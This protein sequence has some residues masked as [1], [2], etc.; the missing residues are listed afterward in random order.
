MFDFGTGKIRGLHR[1][2]PAKARNAKAAIKTMPQMTALNGP[3]R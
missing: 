1:F 2:L 3:T